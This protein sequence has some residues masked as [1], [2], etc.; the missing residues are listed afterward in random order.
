[1]RRG[2]ER[3]SRQR[4]SMFKVQVGGGH[5]LLE[6]LRQ[7]RQRVLSYGWGRSK[8]WYWKAEARG[9]SLDSTL[10]LLGSQGWFSNRVC[11]VM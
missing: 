9:G 5:S 8:C 6:V 3:E 7:C 11:N 10:S 1:M 2:E 4:N